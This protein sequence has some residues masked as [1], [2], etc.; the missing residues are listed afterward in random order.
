[1]QLSQII[2]RL[3]EV[4]ADPAALRYSD[5]HLEEAIR[6][7]MQEIDNR[8][9]RVV[10][11]SMTV[12]ND[13]R[14]QPLSG[15]DDPIYLLSIRYTSSSGSLE[16]EPEVQFSYHM[17]AGQPLVHFIG[18]LV[19]RMGDTL[20]VSYAACHTLS[21]LDSAITTTLPD[22]LQTALVNGAAGHAC[23][24]RVHALHGTTGAKPGE[25]GQLLQ[26]AQLRLDLFQ[27]NLAEQKVY[28]EFGFPRGFALDDWDHREVI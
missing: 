3:R 27:K 23:L 25:V 18:S 26:I 4:L 10:E 8:L 21:G 9:P 20:S 2:A 16:L 12:A 24:Q 7:A 6:Q 22:G 14:D 19:P 17:S 15:L 11:T 13:G 1:M 28:Q 5:A